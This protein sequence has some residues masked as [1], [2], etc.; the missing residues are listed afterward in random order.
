MKDTV[1][2]DTEVAAEDRHRIA[3]GYHFF[4]GEWGNN[5]S[6]NNNTGTILLIIINSDDRNN[7]ANDNTNIKKKNCW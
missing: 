4:E 2:S 1:W 5:N 3:R 7:N 6:T